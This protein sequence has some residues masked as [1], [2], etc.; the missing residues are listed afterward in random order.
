MSRPT[1]RSPEII[2]KL[3]QAF[4]MDCTIA[5]A[6]FYAGISESTYYEWVKDDDK[7]SDR[8]KGLRNTPVLKARQAL[9]KSLDDPKMALKY[10]ERKRKAEFSTQK[11]QEILLTDKKPAEMTDD[12]LLEIATRGSAGT[13]HSQTSS[14]DDK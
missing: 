9:V 4:S 6:C 13:V 3:E 10:L 8:F 1:K 12:E 11:N 7:L 5:E 14:Q 2:T